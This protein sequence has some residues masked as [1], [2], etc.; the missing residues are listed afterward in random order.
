MKTKKLRILSALLALAMLFALMPTAAFADDSTENNIITYDCGENG[1]NVTATLN[2]DTGVMTISGSGKMADYNVIGQPWVG[3]KDNIKHLVVENGVTSIGNNA[4]SYC[5]KLIDADMSKA[6]SLRSISTSFWVCE[7]LN[8]VVLNEGLKEIGGSA[9]SICTKLKSIHIPSTVEK[10]GSWCFQ[11]CDILEEVTFANNSQLTAIEG[12][13]FYDCTKLKKI[14]IPKS[15]KVI[16][17]ENANGAF[18]GCSDLKSVIFEPGSQLEEVDLGAFPNRSDLTIYCEESKNNI[19]GGKG[20]NIKSLNALDPV[21][22]FDVDGDTSE[23]HV[24]D[25]HFKAT[26]PATDPT[27]AGYI[28]AGWYTKYKDGNWAEN[29]FDFNNTVIMD[30]MTLYAK[31]NV[32]GDCGKDGSTVKWELDTV[33][34]V[35][36]ISGSGAMADYS[37][38]SSQPWADQRSS[39][40]RVVIG[41]EVTSIGRNAFVNCPGLKAVELPPN[42]VL[43]TIKYNAFSWLGSGPEVGA[44]ITEI[45]IPKSVKEIEKFAFDGCKELATVTFAPD[46]ELETIGSMAF[47]NTGISEISIP[48]S[49]KKIG[50][51]KYDGVSFEDG[52][53]FNDC[54]KLKKVIF[55]SP[56]SLENVAWSTFAGCFTRVHGTVYGDDN[57]M[58]KLKGIVDDDKIKPLTPTVTFETNGGSKV[59]SQKV[60]NGTAVTKPT[61]PTRKGYRFMGWYE[62]ISENE[63]K[64]FDFSTPIMD[65]ITLYAQWEEVPVDTYVVTV[66]NG[67]AWVEADAETK[68]VA[69]GESICVPE[70]ATVHVKADE[71]AFDGMTFERWEVRKGEVKLADDHAAE[72]TFTMPAGEVQLEAMYQAADVHDSGWDAATVVTGAVIGTGTAI[73]AYHIGME[74]YAEQVLGKDVA[75]PRTRGEVALLAWQLAGSPAVNVEG[76]PLSEAAQAERWAVESGLMQPDAEGNFNG[77]KKMSKWNALRVLDAAKKQV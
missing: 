72:T 33:T 10:I 51:S 3:Q 68:A 63:Y 46:S 12:A 54:F 13:T 39:I 23:Q 69:A 76:E 25:N 36:T 8:N 66:E 40:N 61:A 53:V 74:V 15:V 62:E 28:F 55:E 60:A 17:K 11:Q 32:G 64:L 52:N 70:G 4:F 5:T 75:V 42:G 14:T 27:K 7:E 29:P 2:T 56:S 58:S 30:N 44:G 26:K 50:Y 1:N 65:N 38:P 18:S 73:L 24:K 9:F 16:K 71:T 45:T 19:L 31:W 43:E 20:G 77:T 59:D 35:M 47:Q 22:T 41:D 49:V 57:V 34:G 67:V 37:G 6:L 48:A 21:V